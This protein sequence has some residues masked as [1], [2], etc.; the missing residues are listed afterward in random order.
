MF[1]SLSFHFHVN[2]M[3]YDES[4]ALENR[5]AQFMVEHIRQTVLQERKEL[6]AAYDVL[7]EEMGWDADDV[8]EIV[9]CNQREGAKVI[10][11]L[12]N[13]RTIQEAIVIYKQLL[14]L[15]EKMA[16]MNLG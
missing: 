6:T 16:D 3:P 10:K 11:E 7:M 5:V 13:T 8:K 1:L 9:S 12:S 14:S 15:K 2:E 4:L